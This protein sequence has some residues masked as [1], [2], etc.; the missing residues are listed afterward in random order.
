MRSY[1]GILALITFLFSSS[2]YAAA[3]SADP[4]R[5]N[6]VLIMT[7]DM[8]WA[9][10]G[11]YGAPDI[12]TPNI[13]SLARDGVK[14]TDFYSNG[15]LCTPTRAGLMSG[16]YQQRYGL[17]IAL[18]NEGA[19]EADRG[20]PATGR[21]LPRLLR[22]NGYATALVG[23]WHLGYKAEY[24]PNTHGFDYFFGLKSGYHDYYTHHSGNGKP[25]LWE[26]DRP[27]EATGYMTDLITERAVKFIEQTAGRPFFIDV[28]YNAPH[29]PYQVPD[30]PSVAPNNGRHVMP[31]D[32]TTSTRADYVAMVE[33]VD[34]GVGE[35]LRALERRG[36]ANTT[37][38]IFTND[39][40]GEWLASNAPLFNRKLTVW[41]GGIRVPALIRWPGRIPAGKV[42]DQVGITM[43]LT[44]SILAATGT[45]VPV[46]ARLEGTNL[47][48]ILEGRVPE[49]ER[50]LFW[51][52]TTGNRSQKAVRRGDWKVVIDG[53]HTFVFNVRTDI[54]ERQDLASRRQ[55]IAQK[56]QPLLAEWERDVDAEA[57]G[58]AEQSA[59]SVKR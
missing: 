29:W 36:V 41:E 46:E 34:R 58:T 4:A 54:S 38:V 14:L 24:S 26:N 56:L 57:K 30:K 40:G 2:M 20:L 11:S 12:R 53:T 6:V 15:V 50:T 17:E 44:A 32:P 16:R 43:D 37:I 33:R 49:V 45:A 52:T 7:D 39:N 42:S 47:L 5:P 22:N 1:V 3:Q 18:P 35:V 8:G 9:D 19:P 55:D 25:D 27:I 23:K 21:T 48:P 10:I 13:D 51:R 59:A 31:G 28:A